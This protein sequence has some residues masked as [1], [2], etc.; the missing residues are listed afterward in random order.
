MNSYE[1]N[2]IG[3]QNIA[4]SISER[5]RRATWCW[6]VLCTLPAVVQAADGQPPSAQQVRFFETEIRPLLL[7]RCFKCHAA[8]K[9]WGGLRLDSRAALLRGG[10]SGPAVVPGQPDNSLLIQAV[11]QLDDDLKMPQN[12]RLTARQVQ[13]LVRWVKMGA[14]FPTTKPTAKRSRDAAHWAFQPLADP[15]IPAVAHADWPQSPIDHFILQRLE[16]V[17]LSPS[18]PA[19]KRTLIRRVTFD[20]TGLPPTPGEV[21]AY[22]ADRSPDA[23]ARLVDRLLHSPHYGER[24]G[25]HWL[26]VARYADSN[27]FDEN[28]AH[29]NAW[30]YRDYVVSAVNRDKPFDRFVREQ[31]AGDLLPFE[32]QAQR[33]EQ[34][35][36]TGF[37]SIGPKV[38]AETDQAKMRMDIIDEQLDTTGR[39]FLGL[40]FGC[41]RCHDHKFDPIDTADY[42]GLAGIFKSTLSMRKYTKVAEWHEHLLPSAEATALQVAFDARVEQQKSAI[43][44]LKSAA[45]KQVIQKLEAK[46][47]RKPA[48]TD[49]LEAQYP[50]DTKAKLK[51]LRDALAALQKAGPNLPAA[52]GVTEDKVVDIAIHIRG[53]PLK[54]GEV[55]PRRTPPAVRGPIPPRFNDKHS[56]RQQ[57]AEWLV[58]PRHPLTA[59]VLVNRVWRWHFGRGLVATTDNFGLLGERP[60]HP[61]LLDWLARRFV[62]DGWSLKS[63]HRLILNS[64]TYQQTSMAT[65]R[66]LR[67]DLENRLFGRTTVHRLEAEAVR[68]A[69]LA[70]SGQLDTH[71]GGSLLKLKNR[72]YFFDHTSKD[73]TTY[74]TRRRSLYLPIVRNNVYDVFQLL[75]FP[76]PAVSNG[77]RATTV[78][79]AQALLMLNS[80]LVMQSASRFAERLLGEASD[81]E[82]RLSRLYMLAFGR[83]PTAKERRADQAFLGQV[84]QAPSGSADPATSRQ[85]AWATLC[86]VVLAANEFIYIK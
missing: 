69:L 4:R 9:Q 14:P 85:Q 27:G 47:D 23:F 21:A 22:L 42:Y 12:G 36:A 16:S 83:Q 55:I 65:P 71:M 29:G 11:R 37:L 86:H 70:V 13:N 84:R 24:W 77:D 81:D 38:L 48:K 60:S 43:A 82:Q 59:R 63:L 52:M 18:K 57:L 1:T 75:D 66:A 72:A 32:G 15:T 5:L 49:K 30:R 73:L 58:D 33:R 41:A 62:A 67:K 2:I 56:G 7:D 74:D 51:K 78:V 35:T 50:P 54:L 10:E 40:T 26:D 17:E 53:N 3:T 79:A 61:Q 6:G 68:D 34:L 8:K 44:E 80:D 45:D 64:S 28:V 31:L 20:L 76:D 46:S 39:A 19:H 25:R